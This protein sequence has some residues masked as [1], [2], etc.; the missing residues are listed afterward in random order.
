LLSEDR[1]H[2]AA[3]GLSLKQRDAAAAW[4]VRAGEAKY[5][6]RPETRWAWA[7]QRPVLH[8]VAVEPQGG[9]E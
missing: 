6:I 9:A 8:L 4:L 2:W 1:S 5:E 3:R 7:M